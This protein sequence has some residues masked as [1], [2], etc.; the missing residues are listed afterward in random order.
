M[1][2]TGGAAFTLLLFTLG[3]SYTASLI[4]SAVVN[5]TN[6]QPGV[7]IVVG[8]ATAIPACLAAYAYLCRGYWN[9]IYAFSIIVISTAVAMGINCML[10]NLQTWEIAMCP[11]L[12]SIYG[13]YLVMMSKQMRGLQAEGC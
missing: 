10:T 1:E 4:D 6:G 13:L 8:A 3:L 9:G 2:S 12:P 7:L 11:T 5:D